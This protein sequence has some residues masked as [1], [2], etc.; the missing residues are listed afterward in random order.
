MGNCLWETKVLTSSTLPEGTTIISSQ[1]WTL[2]C[3]WLCA[4]A[5]L[6]DL[7]KDVKQANGMCVAQ[8]TQEVH[9]ASFNPPPPSALLLQYVSVY[10]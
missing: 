9:Q 7:D 10:V 8:Q 4:H 2:Y 5:F 6:C 1:K 3:V